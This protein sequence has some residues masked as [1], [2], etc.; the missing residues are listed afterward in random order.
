MTTV[1]IPLRWLDDAAP[2]LTLGGV[3]CG[4]PLAAGAVTD[5]GRLAVLDGSGEPVSA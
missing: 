5:P 4:V 3:T 2:D 1:D